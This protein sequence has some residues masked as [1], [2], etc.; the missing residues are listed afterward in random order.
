[1][2]FRSLRP[3]VIVT[4]HTPGGYIPLEDLPDIHRSNS[5]DHGCHALPVP[6]V[7][8][9]GLHIPRADAHQAVFSIIAILNFF[10]RLGRAR[11][12]GRGGV[13]GRRIGLLQSGGLGSMLP[14]AEKT[15]YVVPGAVQ[16]GK[17]PGRFSP[18]LLFRQRVG[19]G[20][21]S[22]ALRRRAKGFRWSNS[23]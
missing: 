17:Q 19:G 18:A 5:S 11:V 13:A 7:H 8:E 12:R 21:L 1:M 4:P 9:A 16:P 15:P 14:A 6:I 10:R 22:L 23:Y 20:W 3:G 2:L